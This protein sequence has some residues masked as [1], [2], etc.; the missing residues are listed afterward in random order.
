MPIKTL[1]WQHDGKNTDGSDFTAAE[2]A[3]FT[4]E[5]DALPAV[6]IPAA[7]KAPGNVYSAPLSVGYGAHT[8]RMY[9]V[10]KTGETSDPSPSVSFTVLDTRKP[11]SPFGLSAA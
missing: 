1:S 11:T 7:W 3:G 9:T 4:V 6:S 10:A 2:F 5:V 8:A